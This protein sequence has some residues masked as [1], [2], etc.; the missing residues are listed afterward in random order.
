MEARQVEQRTTRAAVRVR[1]G[2][3]VALSGAVVACGAFGCASPGDDY[4][5]EALRNALRGATLDPD[6]S[7]HEGPAV[8]VS[9]DGPAR[10][11][12]AL[13][14]AFDRGQA[15]KLVRTLDAGFR[16][17]ANPYYDAA[18]DALAAHLGA[19]GYGTQERLELGWLVEPELVEA[20]T[21]L[22]ARVELLD[23]DGGSAT[24]HAFDGPLDTQRTLIVQ[25][26][27]G[28]A[29][30]GV[31]VADP[32]DLPAD[33]S[34]VL[35]SLDSPSTTLARLGERR[36]A[37]L[38]CAPL[39]PYHEVDGAGAEAR[40]LLAYAKVSR[41]TSVPC[42]CIS[43]ATAERLRA[44][45]GQRVRVAAVVQSE[46]R[47]LRHLVAT[48]RGAKTPGEA[49][50]IAAHADEPGANDNASGCAGIAV[51]AAALAELLREHKLEWPSASVSFV[52]GAEFEQSKAWIERS[53]M[54]ARAAIAADMLGASYERTGAIALLER[55]PD[56]ALTRALPPDRPSG[57]GSA[58]S[59][60]PLSSG[61]LSLLARCA[62][63]DV[64]LAERRWP[65]REHPFEGGSDHALFLERS[66]PAVL[67]WHFPDRTY[68]TNL[69]R[70]ERVDGTELE[71]SSIAVLATALAVADPH[72]RDFDRYLRS[73]RRE[74]ELRLTAA[75]T[76]G[77][78][79]LAQRW[80]D[81]SIERRRW[82][83]ELC[84]PGARTVPAQ[85]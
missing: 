82:L 50:V 61:G 54:R 33:G 14:R 27:R 51:G 43:R 28:V 20:W 55:E 77:D 81:W 56:P 26:S 78:P 30:V 69:D 36:A 83:R 42:L 40:A 70:L 79:A 19:A 35:V 24:L 76:A 65:S 49:V 47:P 75:R 34:G 62:L 31:V 63:V 11:V 64:G 41:G 25:G 59:T 38:L 22:S 5:A 23:A 52:F 72:P 60:T 68:H 4:D 37:A 85:P 57:W 53:G 8:Y 21:P 67:F 73:H 9:A 3:A 45:P 13:R 74:E 66:I 6:Q 46:H 2:V 48:V 16:A 32:H 39:E 15:T 12:G 17:P 1:R 10:F 29:A 80:I 58:P 84:L 7:F 18:L 44:A 71:R